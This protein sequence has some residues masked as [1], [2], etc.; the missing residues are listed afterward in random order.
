[1]V[2]AARGSSAR[3]RRLSPRRSPSRRCRRDSGSPART[4]KRVRF[5]SP[6]PFLC[7]QGSTA[8]FSKIGVLSFA[9]QCGG[10]LA[11]RRRVWESWG[12]DAWVV[13]VLRCGYR[14]LFRSFPSLSRVPLP[15]RIILPPPSG[16]LLLWLQW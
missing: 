7:P 4:G 5:D 3:S 8:G 10:C 2:E 11:E 16:G 13:Q 14:I 9:R 1:M 6:A 15:L 12:A